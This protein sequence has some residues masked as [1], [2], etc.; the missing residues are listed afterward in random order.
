[1][2]DRASAILSVVP[3]KVS[4]RWLF[5]R[6]LQEGF[7]SNKSDYK[8]R[9]LP[10]ISAARHESYGGWRPDT[11]SDET[12]DVVERGTG[13]LSAEGWMNAV[14]S[15]LSCNLDKW[16]EQKTYVELWFEARAMTRQFEYYTSHI[17]LRPMGGQPSIPYKY[18]AARELSQIEKPIVI[19]YFGDLDPAGEMISE[20]V[21][22]DV[23]KWCDNEFEFI[24]CGLNEQQV[25]RYDVPENPDK[26][27][28]FQWEA[29]TDDAASEIITRATLSYIDTSYFLRVE[30]EEDS[31]TQWFRERF[32][33]LADEW[34]SK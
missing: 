15:K 20:V 30:E 5:Y 6:L 2:L 24:H 11:L 8:S 21:E 19:L 3:Y 23:R 33:I 31:V 29:L 17:T 28:Q 22:R 25:I 34:R 26:P 14:A 9:F 12:R 13:F 4:A 7:Y 18:R 10:A 32:L 1:M 27:G 16:S